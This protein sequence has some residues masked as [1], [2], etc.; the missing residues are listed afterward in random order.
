[1]QAVWS[2]P[3][4]VEYSLLTGKIQGKFSD[5]V[6]FAFADRQILP[7]RQIA[8]INFPTERNREN[9]EPDQGIKWH[10]HGKP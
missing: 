2:H 10:K 9:L 3:V 4:S 5:L 1:M 8:T 6:L 7:Q